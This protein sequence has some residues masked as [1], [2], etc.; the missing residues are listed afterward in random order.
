MDTNDRLTR[1][2]SL[3]SSREQLLAA[4]RTALELKQAVRNGELLRIR[5]GWYARADEWQ[6]EHAEIR[7]IARVLATA[8]VT[9][10]RQVFSHVSAAALYGL[11]LYR[12]SDE[13]VHVVEPAESRNRNTRRVVRHRADLDELSLQQVGP[14]YATSIDQTVLD[15]ARYE[16]LELAV[17]CINEAARLMAIHP[18]DRVGWIALL[19]DLLARQPDTMGNENARRA[20]RFADPSAESPLESVSLLY[21]R[22]LG[23]EVRTQVEIIGSD[24]GLYRVDFELVGLNVFGEVDGKVKYVDPEFLQGRTPDEALHRERHRQNAIIN[25][26]ENRMIRWGDRELESLA[27]FSQFLA[28]CGVH[29]PAVPRKARFTSQL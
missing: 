10:C 11:P 9:K 14:L 7:H 12:F 1:A 22:L 26:G 4:G 19:R 25:V 24:G 8:R 3:I 23:F 28:A 16:S 17:A 2:A 18:D 15:V 13:R 5:R 6:F 27:G 20:L 21:L 29:P